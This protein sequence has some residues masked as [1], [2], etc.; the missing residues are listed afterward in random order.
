V[1]TPIYSP[2]RWRTL[3]PLLDAALELPLERRPA[4]LDDACGGDVALRSELVVLLDECTQDDTGL[5][6]LAVERFASLLDDHHELNHLRAALASHYALERELGR[7]GMG[8]VYLARD[9][10]HE[11]MVA[12]KVLAPELAGGTSA[13]RF[14]DEIRL[15]A[16]LRHPQILPLFDSGVAAGRPWYVTPYV[17]GGTLRDRL[18][19]E[20]PLPLVDAL[21]LLREVASALAFAHTRGVV[22][23]DVKPENVL[24]D[25]G[26]AVL[27]DF[28]I[29][30]AIERAVGE[31]ASP[32]LTALTSPGLGT[33]AYMAPEQ[34]TP[35]APVDH[36]VDLYAL[37]VIAHE[38]LYGQT[39]HGGVMRGDRDADASAGATSPGAVVQLGSDL[40]DELST[41]I[42]RLLAKRPE[43]RI[44]TADE[45][46]HALDGIGSLPGTPDR[47]QDLGT[48][49]S[50][51]RQMARR[52]RVALGVLATASLL[53]LAGATGWALRTWRTGP[54]LSARRVLVVPF[55][56][57]TGDPT[58][59]PLGRMAADW[60]ARGLAE[61]GVVEV[62]SESPLAAEGGVRELRNLARQ[63]GAGTLV[64]G[65]YYLDDDS[66]RLQ[67]RVTSVADWTL[68]RPVAP[69]VAA[70]SAPHMLLEP[71]RQRVMAILAVAH[72][73][74]IERWALGSSPPTF[75]AYE[76]LLTGLDLFSAGHWAEA[77]P[78]W[79]RA[80]ALDSSF[81]QPLLHSI[82]G[83]INLGR[84]AEADSL[85]LLLTRREGLTPFDRAMLEY[86]RA[87]VAGDLRGVLAGA[88][89]MVRAVPGDY[90]PYYLKAFAA[91]RVNRPRQALEAASKISS[92]VSRFGKAW[93]S[94]NYWMV[95]TS[96]WHMLGEHEE[97]LRAAR[98][99]RELHP[100]VREIVWFELRAL[101]ALGRAREVEA[102]VSEF[103]G[104]QATP[105]GWT[106][107][108]LFI[109]LANELEAHGHTPS[110]RAILL[111]ADRWQRSREGD[112]GGDPMALYERAVTLDHLGDDAAADSIFGLLEAERPEDWRLLANRGVIAIRQ[113]RTA[114]AQRIA[115]RLR[116]LRVPY[117]HG[118]AAFAR[119]QLAA[120]AGDLEEALALLRLA[121]AEGL[122]YGTHLHTTPALAPLW[123]EP[124][125]WEL[126]RPRG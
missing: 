60:V 35:G 76:Q 94:V 59:A 126:L 63:R 106:I 39:P 84:W 110:A 78:F 70:R 88:E 45:L 116:T 81:V 99:A 119:A 7:G 93:S 52:R 77:L 5:G 38:M 48:T 117:E 30:R 109:E 125:F 123:G 96:A 69:V 24:L 1:S 4:F 43:D 61:T 40:P 15:T 55:E 95:V 115:E 18:V 51:N 37:G 46:L 20:G 41:L 82:F 49:H 22:H 73:P 91:L 23:R 9:L 98:E 121:L 74:R 71:L 58:L 124:E 68:I 87:E 103:E 36:R 120:Q 33:P 72:D 42:S 92:R 26:G 50:T 17:E 10:R 114:E 44:Q 111:R 19:R 25:V 80:A 104:L 16:R 85:S 118:R 28:G 12:V 8:T 62:T 83:H 13:A 112:D 97:E 79:E 102:R 11:R 66:V 107:P 75:E 56:N 6:L 90:L 122:P 108:R 29:A 21:R 54:P 47:G 101:T 86:Q 67:A 57:A 32:A 89:G 27:A 100:G 64:S 14:L 31:D 53:A 113:G 3:E 2:E 65:T 34:R 105:A